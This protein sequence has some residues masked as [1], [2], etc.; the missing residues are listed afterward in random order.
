MP[1]ATWNNVIIAQS[2]G[3]ETVEGNIYFPPNSLELRYFTPS[4]T[5]TD[6]HWKGEA[7]YYNISTNGETLINGAWFY[8]SPKEAAATIKRYVAFSKDVVISI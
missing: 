6:C 5:R 1:K 3:Y 7:H 4:D 2:D 8:P